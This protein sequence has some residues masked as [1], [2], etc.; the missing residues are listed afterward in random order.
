MWACRYP[1]CATANC[2]F[3]SPKAGMFGRLFLCVSLFFVSV[4]LTAHL[5]ATTSSHTVRV[6]TPRSSQERG[7]PFPHLTPALQSTAS[8]QLHCHRPHVHVAVAWVH[9]VSLQSAKDPN[10]RKKKKANK[11]MSPLPSWRGRICRSR[12]SL[13]EWLWC[14][15][16][17]PCVSTHLRGTSGMSAEAFTARR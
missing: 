15:I 12:A 11:K 14:P 1:R 13:Q 7:V 10:I 6:L 5:P 3:P 4:S 2:L 16:R 9:C 17:V 8:S